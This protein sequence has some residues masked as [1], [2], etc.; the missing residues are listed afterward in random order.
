MKHDRANM[1]EPK[2][3]GFLSSEWWGADLQEIDATGKTPLQLAL[4][5]NLRAWWREQYRL[6]FF[7]SL[8]D[9]YIWLHLRIESVE[10]DLISNML[11]LN[12]S[13]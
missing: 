5:A 8:W 3:L 9:V 11:Q 7:K 2:L 4:A 6:L 1:S 10:L 12:V 13:S